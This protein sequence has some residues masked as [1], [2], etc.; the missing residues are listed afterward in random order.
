MNLENSCVIPV[1]RQKL[2]DF[3]MVVPNV[4]SCLPGA[5][6]VNALDEKTYEGIMTLK[7]GI[8]K[9]RLKGEIIVEGMDGERYLAAMKMQAAD[10]RI[11]GLIQ[12]KMSMSL[13]EI[14]A[15]ETKLTVMTDLNLLG[16]IGEFGHG[17]IKKKADQMM[18]EFAGNVAARVSGADQPAPVK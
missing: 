5:E 17:I 11:S 3:M 14:S 10:Q 8:V 13:D 4:A 16:K 9:L 18:A 6:E 15:E 2:W 1:A 7:V 12:G